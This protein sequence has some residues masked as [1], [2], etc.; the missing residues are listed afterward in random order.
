MISSSRTSTLWQCQILVKLPLTLFQEIRWPSH[1][2]IEYYIVA[3]M[4]CLIVCCTKAKIVRGEHL[5]LLDNEY[6]ATRCDGGEQG[7]CSY[8]NITNWKPALASRQQQ[9]NSHTLH[10]MCHRNKACG[11]QALCYTRHLWAA[12][13]LSSRH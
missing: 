7:S 6:R 2:H 12:V 4:N 9:C 3:T 13:R 8:A 11:D 10:D 1:S 5:P